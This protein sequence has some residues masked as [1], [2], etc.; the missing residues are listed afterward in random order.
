MRIRRGL[1]FLFAALVVAGVAAVV[2]IAVTTR[3]VVSGSGV[4][5]VKVVRETNGIGIGT[6]L[7]NW[8]N[9]PGANLNITVPSGQSAFLL[10]DFASPTSC[11]A[12]ISSPAP[13]EIECWI[14]ILVNGVQA[15]PTMFWQHG[16]TEP[17]S[18]EAHSLQYS[19]DRLPAGTYP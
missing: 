12:Q 9:I 10:I 13:A 17:T 5:G 14:R 11:Q 3:T 2:A 8:V 6:G 1:A 4:T 7:N 15:L 18:V 19:T 16:T